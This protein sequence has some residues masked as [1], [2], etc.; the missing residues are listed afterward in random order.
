MA[1][2]V[3][4]HTEESGVQE[5]VEGTDGSV[6]ILPDVVAGVASDVN[7]GITAD[8]NAAVAAAAGLRLMGYSVRE[9]K[10][11]PAVCSFD[12]VNGATG[13]AGA[14]LAYVELALSSGTTVWFG[15]EG[16][17]AAS[18]LSVDFISGQFD[19]VLYHKTK[20]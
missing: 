7:A 19:L 2:A 10:S 12:I 13:A 8:I 15:P 3:G 14:D 9:S 16:L 17:D 6:H 11:S 1:Y 5:P 4:L 18:G 20:V